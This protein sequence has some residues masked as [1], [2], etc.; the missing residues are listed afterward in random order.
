[1]ANA[2]LHLFGI[3]ALRHGALRSDQLRFLLDEQAKDGGTPIGELARRRGILSARQVRRLLELQRTGSVD[4]DATSF[5]GLLLQNGFASLDEVGIALQAQR[6]ATIDQP[7]PPLGEILV[8]MG[9]LTTQQRGAIL[10]AQKRLRGVDACGELDYETRILPALV[11]PCPPTPEPQGWL[12]Q[13]T[14][15]DLGSL[16][17]L[18]QRSEL[19]RLPTHDVPVPDMAASRD[20]AV[21][22]YSPVERRHVVTDLDSRNGTFLNGAQVI[23]PH[24]LNPGDRIQIGSTIFRYVAG[25]G[26]GGGHNTIVSRLSQG[27]AS[28]ARDVASKAM[29]MLRGAT[30]SL[31][32]TARKLLPSRRSRLEIILDHR[33]ALLERL[34]YA[35]FEAFPDSAGS[36][37]VA[38]AKRKLDEI[39]RGGELPVIRWA[40][41][42]LAEAVKSLGRSVV[43]KG[44][45][46]EGEMAVIVEVRDL[47]AEIVTLEPATESAPNA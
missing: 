34:G 16:F 25:G 36:G 39:R 42:R 45:A 19:G 7:V 26:I 9:T 31:G 17:P 28:A 40:E 20:H 22:E 33:D 41:R 30:S 29:P 1:M 23:R 11:G 37:N 32:E 3:L 35:A 47:D 38:R 6:T 27:A 15:D 18:A 2:P 43:D 24:P 4:P 8:G 10:V 13:E 44:P 14:G 46:P 5:G 12:I 21:I